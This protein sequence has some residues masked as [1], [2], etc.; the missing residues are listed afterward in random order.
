MGAPQT[1]RGRGQIPAVVYGHN[2]PSKSIAV[3]AK[4]FSKVW[5]AA[6]ATSLINLAM[7]DKAEH[8]VLVRDIQHHPVKGNVIHVDFYQVRLDELIK[9]KVPLKFIGEADAVKNQ[10]GVLVRS[11]DEIEL[12]ALPADLPHDIEVDISVL[13]NFEK[14]IHVADLALPAGVKHFHQEQDIVALVQAPRTEAE[15]EALKTEVKEE[16]A[17]VEGVVKPE[18]EASGEA[19][20]KE[21]KKEDKKE[22]KK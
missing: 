10:G 18:A 1:V 4:A 15:L 7:A 8:T 6:G 5:R 9:A 19:G 22:E 17:A 21:E 20:K 3:D 11:L 12:E 16:V 2:L 13:D 14:V